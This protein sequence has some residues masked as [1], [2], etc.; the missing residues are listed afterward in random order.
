MKA[1]FPTLLIVLSLAAC[2]GDEPDEAPPVGRAAVPAVAT[3]DPLR[4]TVTFVG[5]DPLAPMTT[6]DPFADAD[7]AARA[8]LDAAWTAC[9]GGRDPAATRCRDDAFIAYDAAMTA[10]EATGAAAPAG[11]AHGAPAAQAEDIAPPAARADLAA[12]QLSG[13]R[14]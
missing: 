3:L 1:V 14:G 13:T 4:T 6:P 7:T 2:R 10:A 9:G 8:V 11:A 5:L 12:A